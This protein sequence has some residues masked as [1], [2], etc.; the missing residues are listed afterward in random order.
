MGDNVTMIPRSIIIAAMVG[1]AAPASA[2]EFECRLHDAQKRLIAYKFEGGPDSAYLAEIGFQGYGKTV[3]HEDKHP[4]WKITFHGDHA[5]IQSQTDQQY[6]IDIAPKGETD[7]W[8]GV[9][10]Q[11]TKQIAKGLCKVLSDAD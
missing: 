5:L 7:L 8:A 4:M 11:H 1:L 3:L 10:F 2:A 9:L 6:R